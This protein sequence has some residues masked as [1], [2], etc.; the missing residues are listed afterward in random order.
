MTEFPQHRNLIPLAVVFIVA[1]ALV[2]VATYTYLY[3]PFTSPLVTAFTSSVYLPLVSKRHRSIPDRRFGIAEHDLEQMLLLGFPNDGRYHSV[4][5]TKPEA[6][7]T[8][9]YLRPAQRDPASTWSLGTYNTEIGR[10]SDEA[11]F[12][13]F[14]RSHD[15]M[16]YV[17]GN[18]LLLGTPIGDSHVTPKQYA[19]WYRDAWTLIK[20]ENP[21]A[22][23]GPFGPCGL[24][25]KNKLL[26]VWAAYQSLTGQPM[27]A[28]FFPLHQHV[29]GAW[30]LEGEVAYME[31]WIG[32]LNSYNPRG[33]RWTGEPNYW[34]T[35]YSLSAWDRPVEQADALRYM[36]EFTGWLKVNDLG[37]KVFV[38]WPSCNAGWPDQCTLLVRGRQVTELGQRYLELALE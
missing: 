29:W 36:S 27:P 22:L 24:V 15:G 35:E 18:E 23:V 1:V 32:W 10:W 19:Q 3:R 2:A 37:I 16:F 20:A 11:G 34:L 33:W 25:S 30:T 13:Q 6:T 38:W 17:V 21:S 4:Q 7:D 9:R 26:D 5:H 8:A 12:R 31:E 14:V 28:D